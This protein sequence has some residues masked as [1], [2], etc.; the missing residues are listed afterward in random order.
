MKVSAL[1]TGG[2]RGVGFEIARMFLD[3]NIPQIYITGTN[4]L[5]VSRVAS[6]LDKQRVIPLELDF[7]KPGSL[8]K[9]LE[10]MK[11][12]RIEP[13]IL[14]H[15]AGILD[16]R[17]LSRI[18]LEKLNIL[19]QCNTIGPIALTAQC[20]PFMKKKNFGH[21]LFNSPP[22][23]M[24][25]KTEFLNPYMQSKLAMTTFMRSLVDLTRGECISV[26]SF[27]T[28]FPLRTDALILRNIGNAS[29]W[30]DPAIL[31]RTVEEIVYYENPLTFKGHEL[32]DKDYLISKNVDIRPFL[33][34]NPVQLDELFFDSIL[35][36][37]KQTKKKNIDSI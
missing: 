30:V 13:D 17:D 29:N 36:R 14:I 37:K 35:E 7:T 16:L 33:P 21:V 28:S 27:W 26:N 6:E 15:N 19:F 34:E 11:K 3:R 2:T 5:E 24:D 20:L 12:K 31:A 1:I 4:Y 22:Y 23:K 32:V 8:S 10:I 18:P 25:R 9:C